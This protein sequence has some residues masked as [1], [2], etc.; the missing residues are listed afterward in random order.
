VLRSSED[1]GS[2]RPSIGSRRG[3]RRHIPRYHP[4]WNPGGF[5]LSA[6]ASMGATHP[7]LL[8]ESL[9][10]L[11]PAAP[12]RVPHLGSG[13]PPS[14][15]RSCGDAYSSP[16]SRAARRGR[17]GSGCRCYRRRRG[18]PAGERESNSHSRPWSTR[19]SPPPGWGA[20]AMLPLW[21]R[22]V[23]RMK[24]RNRC[25][26]STARGER[27]PTGGQDLPGATRE[28]LRGEGGSESVAHREPSHDG[29]H[30]QQWRHAVW[31]ARRM[32]SGRPGDTPPRACE[33]SHEHENRVAARRPVVNIPHNAIM[34]DSQPCHD[35]VNSGQAGTSRN[36]RGMTRPMPRKVAMLPAQLPPGLWSR[37]PR[38]VPH[39]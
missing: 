33:P 34:Q 24:L 13:L 10:F 37:A 35:E 31:R 26:L 30:P 4:S 20:A 29:E 12:G 11:R 9:R 32:T 23:M 15:D 25:A 3:E 1:A 7:G 27:P 17:T 8:A 36:S 6:V 21:N 28:T 39:A 5:R 22:V 19:T 14:P 2:G 38:S 18:R 16:S